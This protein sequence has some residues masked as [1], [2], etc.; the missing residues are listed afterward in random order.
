M[1][2]PLEVVN[3]WQQVPSRIFFIRRDHGYHLKVRK[4]LGTDPYREWLKI[5]PCDFCLCKEMKDCL[6]I[7]HGH[8]KKPYFWC[9]LSE[10]GC[11]YNEAKEDCYGLYKCPNV[12]EFY[13]K[14][15]SQ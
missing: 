10:V 12:K 14:K 8:C 5:N 9:N 4:I 3:Q 1:F 2:I 11:E 13:Q 7:Y 15:E 6:G